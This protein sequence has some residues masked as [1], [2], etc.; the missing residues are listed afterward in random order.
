MESSLAER[1][2]LVTEPGCTGDQNDTVTM[3]V[4]PHKQ[5][6]YCRTASTAISMSTK[7]PIWPMASNGPS[8]DTPK[9]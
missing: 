5:A 6:A 2:G 8:N 7:S 3:N 9:S 1:R 4:Q